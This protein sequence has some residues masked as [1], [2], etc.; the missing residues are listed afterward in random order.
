M[1]LISLC[2]SLLVLALLCSCQ[3]AAPDRQM[4]LNIRLTDAPGDYQQ[5][6]IDLMQV[7][8]SYEADTAEEDSFVDVATRAG[9]YDLLQ[10]QNGLDTLIVADTVPYGKI[11]R[12]WLVLGPNSNVMVDSV[13][14]DL[15]TPSAQTSGLKVSLEGAVEAG[16]IKEIVLDFDAE[17]SIVKK[18]NGGYLLKPVIKALP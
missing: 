10:L 9:M 11:E 14:H 4:A 6:N 7:R 18:G 16:T 12:V 3:E 2:I 8:I 13:F 1:R 15:Q 5:V 17:A